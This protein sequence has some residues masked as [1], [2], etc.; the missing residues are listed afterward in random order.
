MQTPCQQQQQHFIYATKKETSNITTLILKLIMIITI[1]NPNNRK[2]NKKNDF[3]NFQKINYPH[4][5][6]DIQKEW[7]NKSAR[8]LDLMLNWKE[9]KNNLLW[10]DCSPSDAMAFS[11]HPSGLCHELTYFAMNFKPIKDRKRV[12]FPWSSTHE[13]Y[14][15]ARAVKVT[16][17]CT[18][19]NELREKLYAQ[20]NELYFHLFPW[21]FQKMDYS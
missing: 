18:W 3:T 4:P 13:G 12:C 1:D 16:V 8:W 6:K 11:M 10:E 2:E 20:K 19:R 15:L 9:A 21:L 7:V 14:L 17:R 5:S